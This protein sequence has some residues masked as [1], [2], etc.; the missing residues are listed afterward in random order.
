MPAKKNNTKNPNLFFNK[1]SK[2]ENKK[3]EGEKNCESEQNSIKL[4]PG[5]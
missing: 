2:K 5:D 3:E 1:N 4:T